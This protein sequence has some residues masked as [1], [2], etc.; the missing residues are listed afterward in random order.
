MEQLHRADLAPAPFKRALASTG[1]IQ[2]TVIGRRTGRP[3]SLPVWFVVEDDTLYLLPVQGSDTEWFK[4][5]Q[6]NP[7]M[8]LSAA[9]IRFDVRGRPITD[10]VKVHEVADKFRAKYGSGNV[11]KYYSKFDVAVEIALA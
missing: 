9:G 5:L 3:I 1:E 2:I 8:I 11:K 4:N 6:K 7:A 10:P